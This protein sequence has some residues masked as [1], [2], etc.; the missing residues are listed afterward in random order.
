M[1]LGLTLLR[2]LAAPFLLC[3]LYVACSSSESSA[4]DSSARETT[5]DASAD[6]K[7]AEAVS[8]DD[9]RATSAMTCGSLSWSTSEVKSRPRNHHATFIVS[10]A[11]GPYLF[12][13]G[14]ADGQKGIASVDAAPVAADGS[15]GPFEGRAPL[16]MPT[17]GLTGGVVGNVIV[18]AGGMTDMSVTAES[19]R[20][21]VGDDGSLG[22]WAPAGST[23]RAR[24]H[25]G[26]FTRGDSIYVLGGFDDPNVWDDVVRATVGADGI[27]SAWMPAGTLPGPRSHASVL[28]RDGFVYLVG[29]LEKSAFDNPPLLNDAWRGRVLDDGSL[30][31]WTA[32]PSF[33]VRIAT[34][35]SFFYGGYLYVAGGMSGATELNRVWRAVIDADH[36]LGEWEEVASLPIARGHVH[37]LPVFGNHVYS[38]GGALDLDLHSTDHV[39]VGVFE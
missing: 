3:T 29:G 8:C 34:H 21:V 18:V 32:M 28:E 11:A 30:G 23:G 25:P 15:L 22:A 9:R 26:G 4:S 10:T 5:Q 19:F 14:G 20:A 2:G 39:D 7:Q 13:I 1:S 36:A 37:Q 16:T 38:V 24:M 17:G 6:A 31:E 35:A 27:V 12:A 33:P